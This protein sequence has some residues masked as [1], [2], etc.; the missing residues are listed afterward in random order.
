MI[1]VEQMPIEAEVVAEQNG[2]ENEMLESGLAGYVRGCWTRAKMAKT[3][4]TERL[5]KCQRQ[6]RGEYDPDRAHEIASTVGSDIFMML[7]YIKA[8]AA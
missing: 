5:L 8:R 7:T 6:R 3:Q 2:L 1:T 4:V